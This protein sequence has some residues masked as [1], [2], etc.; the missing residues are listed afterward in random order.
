[1]NK[2][3]LISVIIPAFNAEFFIERAI[4][5]MLVQ[6]YTNFEILIADDASTDNTKKIIDGFT[7]IRIKRFHNSQNLG[8]L[9]TCNKLFSKATGH[10]I[11]FQDADDVSVPNRLEIQ[12]NEFSKDKELALCTSNYRLVNKKG[13]LIAVR[14]WVIDYKKFIKDINYNPLFCGATI[15]V[16]KPVVDEVGYYHTFFDRLGA[17]DY[18]WLLRIVTKHKAIH[19]E[20]E[21]Y[22]YTI[23]NSAVR[24]NN[25]DRKKYFIHEIVQFIR[26]KRILSGIDVLEEK[27]QEILFKKIEELDKPYQIDSSKIFRN[28]AYSAYRNH[29][30]GRFV[31]FVTRAL[32]K[33]PLKSENFKI[34]PAC[35]YGTI[36]SWIK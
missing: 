20:K 28:E 23:H 22:I 11:T 12:L 19:L 35:I 18:E 8:Y 30:Y 9:K 27:N 6:S 25:T 4:Q 5:S 24:V 1:M 33:G 10:Y 26:E 36:L 7:D 2:E 34:I 17:E 16:K 32:K 3:P 13:K 31:L 29:E 14:K 21:L 15:M